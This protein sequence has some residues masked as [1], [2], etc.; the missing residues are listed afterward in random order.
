MSRLLADTLVAHKN[1]HLAITFKCALCDFTHASK[2]STSLHFR[3]THSVAVPPTTI[4]GSNE[5]ACPFCPL[6]FPSSHS[7]STHIREKHMV[8]ACQQR[9]R[10]AAQKKAQRGE[11]T[12]RMKWTQRETEAFKAALAKYGPSS[13]IKLAAAIGTRSAAQVNVHKCRFLKAYPNWVSENYHPAP[14]VNSAPTSPM[15]PGVGPLPPLA[16]GGTLAEGEVEAQSPTPTNTPATQE[17]GT[18]SLPSIS[19]S[20]GTVL[21]FQRADQALLLLRPNTV[22]QWEPDPLDNAFYHQAATADN[23]PSP[24][25]TS[26]APCIPSLQTPVDLSNSEAQA[27]RTPGTGA[28]PVTRGMARSTRGRQPVT[29]VLSPPPPPQWLPSSRANL[30]EGVATQP[31]SA[32]GTT[33]LASQPAMNSPPRTPPPRT[34]QANLDEERTPSP[35]PVQLSKVGTLRVQRL[36]QMLQL[37]R[38]QPDVGL[39]LDVSPSPPHAGIV[40]PIQT[41]SM[42]EQTTNAP[43]STPLIAPVTL[44]MPH[45]SGEDVELPPTPSQEGRDLLF[46]PPPSARTPGPMVRIAIDVDDMNRI[47]R[48]PFHD[49]LLPFTDRLLGE[50]EWVAFEEVLGRWSVAIKAVITTRDQRQANPTSQWAHRRRQRQRDEQRADAT[51]QS[52]S[53]GEGVLLPPPADQQRNPPP[54]HRASGWHRYAAT[55]AKLQRLYK[56]NPSACVRQILSEGPP[57]YCKDADRGDVLR[58]PISPEE[59]IQ[60]LRRMKNTSPGVDG[61]TYATWRWVDPKGSIMA[62]MFNICRLNSRI[63]SA[64][65]HSTVTLIHKG[66]EPSVLRNWR[67]ISL[68]LTSYK[69]YTAI[70]ARRVTSWATATTSFSVSQKGFLAYDGCSE[71]NFLFNVALEGLLKLLSSNTVAT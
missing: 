50:F 71:H 49:E 51:P 15:S 22:A 33:T 28:R 41:S 21:R 65:K 46:D 25:N 58:E 44:R 14:P 56:A 13:N 2:R 52:R 32:D 68:Q 57:L 29:S 4:D 17:E 66:G 1:I 67:P 6:T 43:A 60:Q 35:V 20:E 37:L 69:L 34:P 8:E 61:L 5:K 70:I 26:L 16:T 59:V 39:D 63:P 38:H 19:L 53:P 62:L 64:W 10:E 42:A 9:T 55:S 18:P 47:L 7:C 12:A 54:G 31:P 23:A 27:S 36:N 48:S 30:G 3:H 24:N 11:S 45:T 40:T